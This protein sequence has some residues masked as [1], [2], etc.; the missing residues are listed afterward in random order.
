MPPTHPAVRLSLI[1]LFVLS[2]LA[3]PRGAGAQQFTPGLYRG[4]EN[5]TG[6]VFLFRLELPP[7]QPESTPLIVGTII[8]LEAGTYRVVAGKTERGGL[9]LQYA[10]LCTALSQ[11]AAAHVL[12]A[13]GSVLVAE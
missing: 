12:A 3:S 8:N 9:N 7:P 13:P 1:L 2:G 4:V 10:S 6:N 5:D 11:A